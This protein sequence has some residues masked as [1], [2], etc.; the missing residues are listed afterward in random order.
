MTKI[1]RW[2]VVPTVLTLALVACEDSITGI[3]DPM[4]EVE[5][6]TA[7]AASHEAGDPNHLLSWLPGEAE[8][9]DIVPG[10]VHVVTHQGVTITDGG[11][12]GT[13]YLFGGTDKFLQVRDAGDLRPEEFTIDLWAQQL[14]P[15]QDP[16]H[17]S[18]GTGLGG[19]S[20][21]DAALIQKAIKDGT[22]ENPGLTYKIS[23]GDGTDGSIIVADV[24]FGTAP[25][26]G[27]PRLKSDVAVANGEWVHVALTVDAVDGRN[28]SL[29][30]NG[31]LVDSFGGPGLAAPKYNNG[32][33]VIGNRWAFDRNNFGGSTF[34]GCIDEV[35]I[36]GRA[37]SASEIAAIYD[38]GDDGT[39]PPPEEP[40]EVENTAPV[41]DLD[42]VDGGVIDEGD[43]FTSSLG[44][45]TDPDVADS[46]TATVDYGDGSAVEELPLDGKNFVL[47]HAYADNGTYEITV[48][49]DDQVADP[50]S[51]ATASV[52]VNNVDPS[53]VSGPDDDEILEGETY[54]GSVSFTDPG[55]DEWTA[56]VD[57]GDGSLETLE[58]IGK[59]FPLSHTYAGSGSGPFTVTVT[60]TD[61]DGG[62]DSGAAEVAVIYPLR[63]ARIKGCVKREATYLSAEVRSQ[64]S[65][66]RVRARG[67]GTTP[68][69]EGYRGTR[70]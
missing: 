60:V 33:I 70:E 68:H 34:N 28:A 52:V 54:M 65:E 67:K 47:S 23:W 64:T 2:T 4:V 29:Y 3:V 20:G 18:F 62:A 43:T 26:T 38:D 50:V 41:I 45:F 5:A 59:T 37:L 55:A 56:M 66:S 25:I 63:R 44:S 42:G 24:A 69:E 49:V 16:R 27:T 46:W 1:R 31:V 7:M 32:S 36:S 14:G 11:V 15:S 30:V 35:R 8:F 61:D 19:Q 10:A 40:P 13:A 22:F 21:N 48:T 53:I 39:C 9:K 12:D 6:V 57:Y 17:P 58:M 51:S